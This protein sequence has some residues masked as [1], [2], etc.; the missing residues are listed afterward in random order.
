MLFGYK[1]RFVSTSQL[2][3]DIEKTA[4]SLRESTEK[5]EKLMPK[6][7]DQFEGLKKVKPDMNKSKVQ[8]TNLKEYDPKLQDMYHE[9]RE[10]VFEI[11]HFIVLDTISLLEETDKAI[12]DLKRITFDADTLFFK[13]NKILNDFA[14]KIKGVK[15]SDKITPELINRINQVKE[16]MKTVARKLYESA[17]AEKKDIFSKHAEKITE[18]RIPISEQ[19]KKLG[20]EVDEIG[21]VLEHLDI[22][23]IDDIAKESEEEL[24]KV[25]KIELEVVIVI[26]KLE[27]H[28]IELKNRFYLL[29]EEIDKKLRDRLIVSERKFDKM[30][31]NIAD[32]AEKLFKEINIVEKIPVKF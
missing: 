28:L 18:S 3:E 13:E 20:L 21:R 32:N 29:E 5:I 10:K 25:K 4:E 16:E 31:S 26:K 6:I 27:N 19:I 11:N 12:A 2:C 9:I 23:D 1:L 8:V 30:K 24:T 7:K 15:D 17:R 14:A 22:D